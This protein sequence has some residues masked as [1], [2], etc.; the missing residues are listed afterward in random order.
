MFAGIQNN[1]IVKTKTYGLSCL[2]SIV[3][4]YSTRIPKIKG[5][6]PYHW[7]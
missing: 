2:S 4:E 6:N 3:V 1:H 5:S 7:E